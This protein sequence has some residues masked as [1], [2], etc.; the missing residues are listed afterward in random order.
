MSRYTVDCGLV[1][2]K[3]VYYIF[4]TYFNKFVTHNGYQDFDTAEQDCQEL[5]D[6][7]EYENYCE[8]G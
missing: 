7:E 4:D 6:W 2:N 1:N 8:F 5:N 3:T